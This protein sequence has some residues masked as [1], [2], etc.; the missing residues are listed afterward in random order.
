[1]P[2]YSNN[3]RCPLLLYQLTVCK[4]REAKI[5]INEGVYNAPS[6]LISLKRYMWE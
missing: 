5:V 6:D 2:M 3:K 4:I 1:M